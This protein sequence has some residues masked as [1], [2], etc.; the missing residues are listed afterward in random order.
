[1]PTLLCKEGDGIPNGFC[2]MVKKKHF[3]WLFFWVEKQ[4]SFCMLLKLLNTLYSLRRQSNMHAT[5]YMV[6]LSWTWSNVLLYKLLQTLFLPVQTCNMLYH[7]SLL[8]YKWFHS[9]CPHSV[10]KVSCMWF[11]IC[12][13]CHSLL[14]PLTV[15]PPSNLRL[16]QHQLPSTQFY[17]LS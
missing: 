11:D 16:K 13:Q 6:K 2:G 1:M 8:L 15:S 10:K 7:R 4:P 17:S 9:F 5:C 14:I 3:C 12:A